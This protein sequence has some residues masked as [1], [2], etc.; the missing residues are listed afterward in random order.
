L[1][2]GVTAAK[3]SSPERGTEV[4]TLRYNLWFGCVE[5]GEVR[6][7]DNF[8]E[9]FKRAENTGPLPFNVLEL[10]LKIFKSEERYYREL[11][12]VALKV[13][14]EGV[15]REL[16][17]E[18]RYI[19]ALIKAIDELDE[20]INLLSEKLED[21][22]IIRHSRITED[23]ENE[24]KQLKKL[25]KEMEREVNEIMEKI[26]PNLCEVTGSL[27]AARLIERAGGLDRLVRLPA[28][29]IQIIGAEKSLYKAFARMKKGKKAKTPKHGI[30]FQHPFIRTLPK[31]KRGKMA[32]H[33]AAKIAIAAKID[34]FRGEVEEG[35]YNSVKRRY[36]ELMRK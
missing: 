18:D 33:L 35:L 30:I 26:A 34:Y 15:E 28:S 13:A 1:P 9:S 32:R 19:I 25:R 3:P 11:R 29:K 27:I 5:D 14:E 12:R 10:G 24:I 8:E 31:N 36:E 20:A 6:V 7:S 22:T 23:F 21:I 16:R 17:S 4:L 2:K